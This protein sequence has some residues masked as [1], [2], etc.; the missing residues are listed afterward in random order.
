MIQ[1]GL[2]VDEKLCSWMLEDA[3]DLHHAFLG[4]E[5]RPNEGGRGS[6]GQKVSRRHPMEASLGL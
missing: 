1:H 3:E 4:D 6:F 2:E 5:D